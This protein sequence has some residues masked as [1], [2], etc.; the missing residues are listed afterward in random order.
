MGTGQAAKHSARGVRNSMTNSEWQPMNLKFRLRFTVFLCVLCALCVKISFAQNLENLAAQI[1]SGSTEQKRDALFEIRNL[2]NA[3]ASRRALPAL[4]DADEIVRATAAFSVI[5]LPKA[6]A[7]AALLPL[8]SDKSEIVR[9]ETAYALGAVQTAAA[10]SPLIQLFQKDKILEVRTASA[11][12]LGATGDA[13]AVP[14]LTRLLE[15]KPVEETE[16]LRRSAARAVGQIAQYIQTNEIK[17]LTPESFLPE[18]YKFQ[19]NQTYLNLS[20]KNPV[21]RAS[22]EV[23]I[24]VLQNARETDDT[25]REA[26]FALGALGDA[27]ALAVLRSHLNSTDYYLAE[28]CRESLKKILSHE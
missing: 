1:R 3:E 16:F 18:K 19:P 25:R 11:I 8:L 10:V 14:A 12:A 26:A 24:K 7:F 13:S 5:Y 27:S 6:E 22:V 28:I 2:Q 20:E 21:F 15:Q 23:L 9:R 4:R 17:V